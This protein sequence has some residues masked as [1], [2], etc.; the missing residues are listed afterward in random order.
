MTSLILKA[1]KEGQ[2]EENDIGDPGLSLDDRRLVLGGGKSAKPLPIYKLV[3]SVLS[4]FN[5]LLT[6]S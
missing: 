5:D 2:E 3:L 6:A 4:F 1:D